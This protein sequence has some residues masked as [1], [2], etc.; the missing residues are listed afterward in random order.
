MPGQTGHR[1]KQ[2]C[3]V[4]GP[5]ISDARPFL[6]K[7]NVNILEIE[8][9]PGVTN[10]VRKC[11]RCEVAIAGPEKVM[12]VDLLSDLLWY[13]DVLWQSLVFFGPGFRLDCCLYLEMFVRHS[14]SPLAALWL[15]RGCGSDSPGLLKMFL[16]EKSL[17]VHRCCQ[18]LDAESHPSNVKSQAQESS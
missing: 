12:G 16:G 2:S 6:E 7:S 14:G 3:Q 8:Y 13:V 15:G 10:S 1:R 9:R 5:T 11:R 18:S 4:F 17:E